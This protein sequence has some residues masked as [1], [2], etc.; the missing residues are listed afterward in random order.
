MSPTRMFSVKLFEPTMMVPPELEETELELPV[1]GDSPQE[2]N[3]NTNA[4]TTMNVNFTRFV[5][6]LLLQG[7]PQRMPLHDRVPTPTLVEP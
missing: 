4:L 2:A 7:T 3:K 5:I 6:V 1:D